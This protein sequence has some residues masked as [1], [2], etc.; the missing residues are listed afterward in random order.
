MASGMD[1]FGAGAGVAQLV[2]AYHSLQATLPVR[3]ARF[4]D[5]AMLGQTYHS[6]ALLLFALRHSA[7]TTRRQWRRR[8]IGST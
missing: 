3:R 7:P 8:L 4:D 5:V 2:R 6:V 1:V